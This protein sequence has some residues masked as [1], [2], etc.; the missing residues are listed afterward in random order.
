MTA[1]IFFI[2]VVRDF[3]SST[4][5]AIAVGCFRLL[6]NFKDCVCFFYYLASEIAQ[7]SRQ[8]PP[9]AI[10]KK[11]FIIDARVL[12]CFRVFLKNKTKQKIV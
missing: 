12:I 10:K 11:L 7:H 4:Q 2:C 9:K 6:P 8:K 1:I 5:R 3:C